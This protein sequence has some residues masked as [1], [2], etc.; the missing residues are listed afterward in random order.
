MSMQKLGEQNLKWE[1][2]KIKVN[3]IAWNRFFNF[4]SRS[5][6]FLHFT[7]DNVADDETPNELKTPGDVGEQADVEP[8]RAKEDKDKNVF[9]SECPTGNLTEPS[10]EGLKDDAAKSLPVKLQSS[11]SQNLGDVIYPG[12]FMN[13]PKVPFYQRLHKQL[14][15]APHSTVR[16]TRWCIRQWV[17]PRTAD[18]QVGSLERKAWAHST[19]ASVA[20]SCTY[21]SAINASKYIQCI[22]CVQT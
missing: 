18:Q 10:A 5:F 15:K 1:W 20:A 13:G 6:L 3:Q 11:C 12:L 8:C 9:Y 19:L 2:N 21:V 16:D 17:G 7:H 14:C 22:R 4:I